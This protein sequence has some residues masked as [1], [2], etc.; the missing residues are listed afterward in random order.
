M[1]GSGWGRGTSDEEALR[2][3]DGIARSVVTCLDLRCGYCVVAPL[4]SYSRDGIE[5]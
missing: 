4:I 5:M 2:A 3:L 1:R